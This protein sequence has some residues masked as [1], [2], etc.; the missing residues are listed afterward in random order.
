MSNLDELNKELHDMPLLEQIT[1]S[2]ISAIDTIFALLSD[3]DKNTAAAL[4]QRIMDAYFDYLRS[5]EIT[6]PSKEQN[7]V[8]IHGNEDARQLI[9]L[10]ESAN[11]KGEEPPWGL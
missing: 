10:L 5:H 6:N 11:E 8:F 1:Q 4:L 3:T 2:N 7:D 9:R